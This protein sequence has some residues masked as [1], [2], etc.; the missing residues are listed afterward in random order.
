MIALYVVTN[1]LVLKL[2]DRF[3]DQKLK[4]PSSVLLGLLVIVVPFVQLEAPLK[5][6]SSTRLDLV[7][8]TAFFFLKALF[9]LFN[10]ANNKEG[11]MLEN[12]IYFLIALVSLNSLALKVTLLLYLLFKNNINKRGEFVFN[13]EIFLFV[14]TLG[15]NVT[16]FEYSNYILIFLLTFIMALYT[17]KI[18]SI[19]RIVF[20]GL[21]FSA[22]GNMRVLNSVEYVF[23]TFLF[24]F[25]MLPFIFNE[26]VKRTLLNKLFSITFLN[27]IFLRF[28]LKSQDKYFTKKIT[29]RES[30]SAD[31]FIWME[32]DSSLLTALGFVFTS[33]L[34]VLLEF[35][36]VF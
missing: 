27:K 6:L 24:V 9:D 32:F 15:V 33:G 1:F 7:F 30:R 18:F 16:S 3:G 12:K 5:F 31:Q 22:C 29:F 13:G 23:Y 11:K 26:P 25:I 2:I 28:K 35:L 20:Y 8:I 17:T 14:I 34:C 21:F 36:N 10:L 4:S 19:E